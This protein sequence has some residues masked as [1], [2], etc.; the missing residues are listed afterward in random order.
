MEGLSLSAVMSEHATGV[1]AASFAAGALL[2][3]GSVPHGIADAALRAG[4]GT[5]VRAAASAIARAVES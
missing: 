1:L 5:A 4:T 3:L 2:S